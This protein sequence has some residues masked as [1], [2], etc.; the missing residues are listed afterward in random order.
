MNILVT[1]GASG[2][3]AAIVKK[4]AANAGNKVYFTYA[5]SKSAAQQM[6]ADFPNCTSL[7]CDFSDAGSM[8]NFI[9]ELA[10]TDIDILV[11]NATGKIHKAH[12]YKTDPAVFLK[13]FE[14]DVLA[15]IRITQESIKLF[16]KKKFGKIINIIS[17]ALINKP[18]IGWSGY[19]A[20][21]AYLL[22]MSNSWA[23][24]YIRSNIT[25]N[26]IS[27]SFMKTSLTSDTDERIVQQMEDEHPLKKLLTTEEVAD[28]VLFLTTATQHINGINL[29]MN[30]GAD[31]K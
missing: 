8:D 19:V 6:E 9:A 24:E 29:I 4:L 1:G 31:L 17:S 7:H 23:T 2:L 25:S 15:T 21:K 27:P 10:N 11:N 12:F 28:T 20:N 14:T 13:S 30:A 3:G 22:S 5:S 18:P 16:R 26:C